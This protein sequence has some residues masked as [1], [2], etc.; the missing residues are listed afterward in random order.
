MIDLM[1]SQTPWLLP[2]L[3]STFSGLLPDICVAKQ[4]I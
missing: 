2:L 4:N 3:H 1:M